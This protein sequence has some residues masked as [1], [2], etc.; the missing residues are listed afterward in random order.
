MALDA[1]NALSAITGE[2]SVG[3]TT[4]TAPTGTGGTL[5][6]FT[7][8]GYLSE[9]G[10]AITPEKS[11]DDLKAWQNAATVRTLTTDSKL[12][13]K[14]T[15]IET[16]KETV[17]LYW[18]TTVTQTATEGSF[19]IDPGASAGTKSFVLDIVDGAELIRY[20]FPAAEVTEREELSNKNG[21][22]IG[23]G[24]TLTCYPA[25]ID[26]EQHSG[27]GWATALKSA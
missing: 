24:I 10:V 9:D 17:E 13:V 26:G 14:F 25:D 18:Q 8:L 19:P 1:S 7:G 20:Y 27:Y 23:Y 6:G 3:A 12:T 11:T 16:K 2:V 5:T 15:M 21:D 4:A 22:L